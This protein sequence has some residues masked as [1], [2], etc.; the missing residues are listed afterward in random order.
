V[1]IAARFERSVERFGNMR[2]RILKLR[3]IC[4][5][6]GVAVEDVLAHLPVDMQKQIRQA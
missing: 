5:R 2:V 3:A 6:S 4:E 1:E